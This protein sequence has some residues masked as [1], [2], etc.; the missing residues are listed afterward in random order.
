MVGSVKK[1]KQSKMSTAEFEAKR[2]ALYDSYGGVKKKSF[3]PLVAC[4][5]HGREDKYPSVIG[6]GK[7]ECGRNNM[8][9]PMVLQKESP[10]VQAEI[11]RKASRLVPQY[12]KGAVQYTPDEQDPSD[13]G[14]KK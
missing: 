11:L 2:K 3:K 7:A 1:K 6:T 4:L 13:L 12:N 10:E 9:E 14:R 8:M 5:E